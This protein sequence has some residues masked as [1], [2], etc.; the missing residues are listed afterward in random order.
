MPPEAHTAPG[1]QPDGS[2]LQQA[3]GPRPCEPGACHLKLTHHLV[4]SQFAAHANRHNAP[5][6]W[7][8]MAKGNAP[9]HWFEAHCKRLLTLQMQRKSRPIFKLWIKAIICTYGKALKYLRS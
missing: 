4:A 1:G 3:Q 2:S 8:L 5:A 9:Q 6:D 7:K